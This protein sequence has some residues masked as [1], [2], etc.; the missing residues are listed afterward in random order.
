MSTKIKA[1]QVV[2]ILKSKP[3]IEAPLLREIV[4]EMN[5]ILRG[6]ESD[7]D[8]PPA[9]KKQWVILVSDPR[10]VLAD[11]SLAGWVLQIPEDDSVLTTP[12]RIFKA[13]YQFNTTK[14]GRLL[15]AETVG[16]ALENVPSHHFKEEDVWIKTKTPVLVVTTNNEI[17][18]EK[19]DR[20]TRED[21]GTTM[22][23]VT[24]DK[25][26]TVTAEQFRRAAERVGRMGGDE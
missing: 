21:V 18:M 14:R 8:K 2:E 22:T 13:C 5:K 9:I 6:D 19:T 20:T 10:G 23:I 7:E 4:E 1:E 11:Q 3:A 12:E 26:V 16:D 17:P 24:G 15:P 25:S